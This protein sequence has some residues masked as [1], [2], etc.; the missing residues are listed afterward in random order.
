[1]NAA[2]L[3]YDDIKL[4]AVY[5]FER[6]ITAEDVK[7]FAELT[8]DHNPLHVDPEF[9]AQ[10][11]FGNNIVHGMLAGSLFST[12]VG[13][14]CPGERALYMSQ[15]LHFRKPLFYGDRVAVRGTMIDKNDSVGLITMKTEIV[16]KGEIVVAGE[17]KVKIL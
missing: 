8:G 6:T 17:A 15:T 14:Y 13:M 5:E 2:Q 10:S 3:G 16:R 7:Q 4:G 1:M 11:Q 12:L 9:G